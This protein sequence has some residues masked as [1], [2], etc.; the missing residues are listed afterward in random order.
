M[1]VNIHVQVYVHVHVH[2]T[3]VVHI[4]SCFLV[5]DRSSIQS[6]VHD[7][8]QL[9]LQARPLF[10]YA[11]GKRERGSGNTACNVFYQWNSIIADM[12]RILTS[13]T[14]NAHL[15][16]LRN[17]IIIHCLTHHCRCKDKM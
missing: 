5:N 14:T 13:F 4:R 9:V 3:G 17:T 12:A 10:D 2:C 15:L 11:E 6:F 8:V 16:N 7:Y 1:S